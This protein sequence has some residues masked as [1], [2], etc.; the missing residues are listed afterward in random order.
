MVVKPGL[1]LNC[2]LAVTMTGRRI[3]QDEKGVRELPPEREGG[4]PRGEAGLAM[5]SAK[6]AAEAI[7]RIRMGPEWLEMLKEDMG[8]DVAQ[9]A[10]DFQAQE[11]EK[12]ITAQR[13]AHYKR[14]LPPTLRA[15]YCPECR[16]FA[17][18]ANRLQDACQQGHR[19]PAGG[20]AREYV[21]AE[22][23]AEGYWREGVLA[24]IAL[25]VHF[26]MNGSSEGDYASAASHLS[27]LL[28]RGRAA[29]QPQ[30]EQPM[31]AV[32]FPSDGPVVRDL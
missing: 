22:S 3:V 7:V 8:E 1:C 11:E 10:L 13:A 18:A 23:V 16:A 2:G 25:M 19:V 24:A 32:S 4:D 14:L 26:D 21:L 29:S 27:A 30:P 12:A 9:Q 31:M 17:T 5:L 28:N 20:V 6:S 15:H